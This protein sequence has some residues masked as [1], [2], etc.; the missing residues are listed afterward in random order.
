LDIADAIKKAVE[1]QHLNGLEAEAAMEEMLSGRATDAQIAAFLIALRMKSETVEELT[2]FARVLRDKVSHV[3]ARISV[4]AAL[5]GTEREML[6]DT[7]GTGGDA[8]GTFNCEPKSTATS[9][10]TPMWPRQSG[11]LLVTSRSIAR[12]PPTSLV[13]S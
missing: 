4:G 7:C 2:G 12:S 1:G 10:A 11:R 5:S 3:P 8:A 9:R 6:V 13:P